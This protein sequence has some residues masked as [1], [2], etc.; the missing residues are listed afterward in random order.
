MTLMNL[1]DC[2]KTPHPVWNL[3]KLQFKCHDPHIIIIMDIIIRVDAKILNEIERI[4]KN[5]SKYLNGHECLS[6]Y[7]I[8]YPIKYFEL[9]DVCRF[10]DT[11]SSSIYPN[12]HRYEKK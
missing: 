11:N 9:N 4:S 10:S 3:L 12:R 6:Q 1:N 7:R 8:E 2:H 5:L